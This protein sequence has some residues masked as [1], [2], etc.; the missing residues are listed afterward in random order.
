MSAPV[1]GAVYEHHVLKTCMP[2]PFSLIVVDGFEDDGKVVI[3]RVPGKPLNESLAVPV[4]GFDEDYMILVG[5][6]INYAAV[7]PSVVRGAQP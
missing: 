6:E 2:R 5:T 4:E 3:V 1:A 7:H